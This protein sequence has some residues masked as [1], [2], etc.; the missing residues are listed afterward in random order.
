MGSVRSVR[1]AKSAN[2]VKSVRSVRPV[3][4]AKGVRGVGSFKKCQEVSESRSGK[5]WQAVARS[6]KQC[7][8][9]ARSD[10][11]CWPCVRNVMN[12]E[13]PSK[14]SLKLQPMLG[15][16]GVSKISTLADWDT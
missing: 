3:R 14:S 12:T 6:G 15:M 11:K 16:Y 1:C 4:S 8:A 10:T 2:S 13:L 5:K 7:Q 9:V